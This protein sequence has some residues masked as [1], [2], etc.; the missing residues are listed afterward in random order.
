MDAGALKTAVRV[1]AQRAALLIAL[2]VA[3]TCCHAEEQQTSPV[4][5]TPVF[6]DEVVVTAQKRT[7]AIE[8]VPISMTVIDRQTLRNTR[9]ATLTEMQQLVPNFSIAQSLS[10]NTVT[11][12]GV[13]GGGRNIGFDT[14]VGVYVDGIYMGQAQTLDQSLF[15]IEQVEVLRGP[16]GHLFGRN[17]VAGAINIATRAPT[18]TF[19][20]TFRAAAGNYNAREGYAGVSGP[21]ADELLGKFAIGYE[22]RDG[23]T[24]NLFNNQTLD[25]LKRISTRGQLAIQANDRLEI[26]LAADYADI[27]QKTSEEATTAMFDAPLPGGLYPGY[28][29]NYNTAPYVDNTLSGISLTANYDMAGGGTLTAITG[30]RDTHQNREFDIDWSPSDVFRV[31]YTENFK[32]LSQ[33]IRVASPIKDSLRYVAGIYLM[34]ESADTYR[35]AVTGQ[36]TATLVTHPI[37]GTVPF[38]VL[39]GLNPGDT[40]PVS[41]TVKTDSYAAFGSLDYDLTGK[42]TLNLGARYTVE[43]KS[44]LYNIDGAASGAIGMGTAVNY[45]DSRSDAMLTPSI[46]ATYALNKSLNLYG[47]YS[48]GFK[49]GG[50]NIDYLTAT[51]IANKFDFSKETVDSYEF[52]LKGSA[53]DRRM[54]YDLSVFHS[55]FKD[56]QVFQ[57]ADLGAGTTELQLKNAAKAESTGAEASLR[58]LLTDNLGIGGNIGILKATFK[59]FPGGLTGGGDAVGKRLPDAPDMTV[60]VTVDY[61]MF[62]SSLG[63][64]LDFYGEYSHRN[65]SFSGVDNNELMDVVSSRDVVNARVSFTAD[66]APLK[67]SL[68]ARNLFNNSYT[69]ARG[70]DFFGNQYLKRGDPRT[71]GVEGRYSF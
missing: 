21:V 44:L 46:G 50:W 45:T 55:T 67:F 4:D 27:R 10:V 24:T 57:F 33:E 7:Q 68:W 51:Q 14:R 30:Y 71:F 59:S 26:N 11:V 36:D 37:A 8:D 1:P 56:F 2:T 17:T 12:R 39:F 66:H 43:N 9:A 52:G 61:S 49:S 34:H 22:T 13:G 20:S 32:Q 18:K 65:K 54:S 60:V 29:V 3:G 41:G 31:N 5:A 16:Q 47:K 38:G 19:E 28:I 62:A 69:T 63:G 70:R 35:L 58:T 42:L 48:T 40:V 25:N 23:F 6:L 53:L 15:D 64:R